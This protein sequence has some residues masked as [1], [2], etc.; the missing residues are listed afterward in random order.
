MK[1]RAGIAGRFA[2]LWVIV[3]LVL[4]LYFYSTIPAIKNNRKLLKTRADQRESEK[5]LR[6][7]VQRIKNM[8]KAL[9][10][11]PITVENELRT[12]FGGAKK[13]DEILL[14]PGD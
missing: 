13:E 7:E 6:A 10:E 14:E 3:G 12:Q 2:P 9:D 11:D 8:L 5:N 1:D 4:L